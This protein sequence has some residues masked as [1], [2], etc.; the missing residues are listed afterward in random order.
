MLLVSAL[1]QHQKLADDFHRL[2][3]VRRRAVRRF[4]NAAEIEE[5]RNTSLAAKLR[6]LELLRLSADAFVP[7]TL[8]KPNERRFASDG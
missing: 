2:V 8:R 6:Q 4:S 3:V 7:N 1:D 5:L